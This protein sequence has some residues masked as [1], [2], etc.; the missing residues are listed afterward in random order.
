R[1]CALE[2]FVH[3]DGGM[4][5]NLKRAEAV[6]HEPAGLHVSPLPVDTWKPMLYG[7]LREMFTMNARDHVERDDDSGGTILLCLGDGLVDIKRSLN[8]HKG[9]RDAEPLRCELQVSAYL[10]EWATSPGDHDKP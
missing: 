9:Q 5:P 10:L 1:L 6:R 4:P 2:D 8:A 3:I 7:D